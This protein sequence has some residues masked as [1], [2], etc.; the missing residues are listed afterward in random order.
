MD[1]IGLKKEND[2][3]ES[4]GNPKTRQRHSA[5]DTR[6]DILLEE[7][8]K[9]NWSW[10][11]AGLAAGYSRSYA[12]TSLATTCLKDKS[13]SKKYDALR[14]QIKAETRDDRELC[15]RKL[16]EM[17]DAEDTPKTTRIRAMELLGKMGGWFSETRIHDVGPRAREL[18]EV[19]R[20]EAQRISR[21]LIPE[22]VPPPDADENR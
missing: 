4:A 20:L 21:T 5:S 10:L 11:N 8:P 3:G 17:V 9:H 14:S 15:R 2:T 19:R 6:R 22:F 18:D 16:L 7:L 12:C 13:F 1:T